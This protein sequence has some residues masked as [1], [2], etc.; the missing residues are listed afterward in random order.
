MFQ[1]LTKIIQDNKNGPQIIKTSSH[2]TSVCKNYN[3]LAYM[4]RQV[5]L[6]TITQWHIFVYLNMDGLLTAYFVQV[7]H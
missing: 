3:I 4:F 2:K 7:D 6:Y 1:K 5:P